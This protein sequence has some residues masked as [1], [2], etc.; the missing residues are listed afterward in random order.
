MINL[1]Q[2]ETS[3]HKA[4]WLI[5]GEGSFYAQSLNGKAFSGLQKMA[6]LNEV[7]IAVL[8]GQSDLENP[9]VA[10]IDSIMDYCGD[11]DFA[12]AQAGNL[13]RQLAVT[14]ASQKLS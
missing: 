14:F 9:P 3:M 7:K 11:T 5:T 1:L 8:C 12:M 2:I 10:Y 6:K 13:L 4:D